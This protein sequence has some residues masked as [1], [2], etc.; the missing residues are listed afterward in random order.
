MKTPLIITI[1]L[2]VSWWFYPHTES[3]DSF[4]SKYKPLEKVDYRIQ[5]K[6]V[7]KLTRGMI[8]KG[9]I[10]ELIEQPSK[11][12]IVILGEEQIQKEDIQAL[13]F[14]LKKDRLKK[15]VSVKEQEEIYEFYLKQYSDAETQFFYLIKEDNDWVFLSLKGN[16]SVQ[17]WLG[18]ADRP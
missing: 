6:W 12:K 17:D 3:I 2:L 16:W 7:H 8:E 15:L 13:Q 1:C 10:Q 18:N 14:G 11:L 9:K 5:E 4:Y